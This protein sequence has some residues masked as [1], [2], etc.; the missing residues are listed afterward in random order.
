M[1]QGVL[2]SLPL[3]P[4]PKVGQALKGRALTLN[5]CITQCCTV[6]FAK[7]QCCTVEILQKFATQSGAIAERRV[8][9][10]DAC[11]RQI[12]LRF[13]ALLRPLTDA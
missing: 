10:P 1:F 4:P 12:N 5:A 6:C 7:S 2:P 3:I 13:T 8:Y 9:F 11:L